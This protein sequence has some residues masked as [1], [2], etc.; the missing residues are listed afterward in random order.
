MKNNA[1]SQVPELAQ[2]SLAVLSNALPPTKS[3][4]G[5]MGHF[6]YPKHRDIQ[7][8]W[9]LPTCCPAS[10]LPCFSFALCSGPVHLLSHGHNGIALVRHQ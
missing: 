10:L 8:T 2:S 1:Y 6:V 7:K 3:P 5:E 9:Q 4:G